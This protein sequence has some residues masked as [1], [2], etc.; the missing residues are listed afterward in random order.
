MYRTIGK[1]DINL[2]VGVDFAEPCELAVGEDA[3][4]TD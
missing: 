1:E 2:Q 4:H 3:S